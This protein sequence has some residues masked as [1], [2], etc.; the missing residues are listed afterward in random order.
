MRLTLWQA[1]CSESAETE[2]GLGWVEKQIRSNGVEVV[3][4]ENSFKGL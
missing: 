3:A 2:A 4:V 1:Q